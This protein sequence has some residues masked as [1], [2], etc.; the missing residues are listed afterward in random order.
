MADRWR[1]AIPAKGDRMLLLG[2]VIAV[3]VVG[4]RLLPSS[5]ALF[6]TR[7]IEYMLDRRVPLARRAGVFLLEVAA[8]YVLFL[9]V[10]LYSG[11]DFRL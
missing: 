11:L 9:I 8:I 10:I 1:R 7:D 4:V 3:F 2:L 5:F 6:R